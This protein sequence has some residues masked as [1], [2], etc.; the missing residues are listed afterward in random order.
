VTRLVNAQRIK[1]PQFSKTTLS[2]A[3]LHFLNR[4]Y[5]TTE[6]V[7]V[8][9]RGL[10]NAYR[11]ASLCLSFADVYQ[12]LGNYIVMPDREQWMMNIEHLCVLENPHFSRGKLRAC[13]YKR[14]VDRRWTN[15]CCNLE[16]L[17]R[18][19]ILSERCSQKQ[20]QQQQQQKQSSTSMRGCTCVKLVCKCGEQ[21]SMQSF[22][23]VGY[24]EIPVY[25][26]INSVTL[27]WNLITR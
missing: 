1:I 12:P 18:F 9:E 6:R 23:D 27:D 4:M 14:D 19:F 8:T 21:A 20:Q 22:D 25:L 2:G 3:N 10:L 15:V 16:C 24:G 13:D 5:L 17:S 11:A 7:H 26:N